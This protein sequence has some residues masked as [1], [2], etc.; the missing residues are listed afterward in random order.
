MLN[1][2]ENKN[3]IT[4][5]AKMYYMGVNHHK[6]Y[7]HMTILDK[8]GEVLKEG[9]VNNDQKNVQEFLLGFEG[10]KAVV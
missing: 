2:P 3:S 6:Q 4:E 7:S 1:Y 10:V 5:G 9:I 8:G